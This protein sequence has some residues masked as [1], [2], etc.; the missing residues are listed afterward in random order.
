MQDTDYHGLPVPKGELDSAIIK[1]WKLP[2]MRGEECDYILIRSWQD[3][4]SY[5]ENSMDLWLEKFSDDAAGAG[6]N[7]K[8]KLLEMT[9]MDYQQAVINE[10]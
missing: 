8:I 2:A 3:F 5:L 7:L 9:K 4:I 6:I 10:E 1:V